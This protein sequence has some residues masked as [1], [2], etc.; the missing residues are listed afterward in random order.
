[1]ARQTSKIRKLSASDLEDL[2]TAWEKLEHPSL[3]ARLTAVVG[4][5]IEE[6]MKLLPRS[7]YQRIHGVTEATMHRILGTAVASLPQ[8]PRPGG[9]RDLHKT[10]GIGLGAAGGYFGLPGV[11]L[12]L[13]VT[14][15]L[16][17]RSIAAIAASEGEDLRQIEGRLACV[18]VFAL[19]GP[20]DDDD[21]AETGYYSLR[22]ALAFHFSLVSQQ[23]IDRGV[24]RQGL[25]IMVNLSR[26]VA[27][28]FGIAISDKIAFQMVP[29][30]GAAGGALLN[31]IFVQ[32]FQDIAQGHFTVR[33]LERDYGTEAVRRAY[34]RFG[35]NPT[36]QRVTTLRAVK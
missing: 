1:M 7:W 2:R 24:V 3:A 25:P 22:L 33:R 18:E 26:A 36:G 8:D 32:H 34:A 31:A 17:L 29:I 4:T 14:T 21:A 11:L 16:I 5:P 10:L 28:R 27:A 35:E 23:L 13:P 6:G 9:S 20:R 30:V 15:G 19:G 12:E